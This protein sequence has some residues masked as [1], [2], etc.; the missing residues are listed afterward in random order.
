MT[1]IIAC[2]SGQLVL[3]VSSFEVS[4]LQIACPAELAIIA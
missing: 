2:T 1:L 4:A 3:S